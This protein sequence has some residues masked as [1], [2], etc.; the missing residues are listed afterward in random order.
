M[1]KPQISAFP[2]GQVPVLEVDGVQIPQSVAIARFLA[3]KFGK[4]LKID[5]KSQKKWNFCFNNL[6]FLKIQFFRLRRK[7]RSRAGARGRHLRS[8]EGLLRRDQAL[9]LR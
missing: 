6:K 8:V 1:Q 7:D 9:L 3:K 5:E 2:Y 4:F